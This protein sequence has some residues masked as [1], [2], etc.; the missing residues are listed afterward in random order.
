MNLLPERHAPG[1][2]VSGSAARLSLS[3]ARAAGPLLDSGLRQI[4]HV[5]R[6][7]LMSVLACALNGAVPAYLRAAGREDERR[8]SVRRQRTDIRCVRP[9]TRDVD[10]GGCGK[11]SGA[12]MKVGGMEAL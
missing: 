10:V 2:R 4:G 9:S 1:D 6:G 11:M 12:W 5:G 8:H 3:G 7:E